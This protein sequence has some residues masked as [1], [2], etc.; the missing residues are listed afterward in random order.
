VLLRSWLG[1]GSIVSRMVGGRQSLC[2]CVSRELDAGGGR[3]DLGLAGERCAK[4]CL[5]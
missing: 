1:H 4:F 5:F 2:V 3:S